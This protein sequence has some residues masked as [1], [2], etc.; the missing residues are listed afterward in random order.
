MGLCVL[1]AGACGTRLLV[2]HAVTD[3]VLQAMNMHVRWQTV[4]CKP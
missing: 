2:G 3:S 1:I 4:S